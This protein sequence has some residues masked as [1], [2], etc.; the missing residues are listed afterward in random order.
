MEP[1]PYES[2]HCAQEPIPEAPPIESL[3]V[4][5]LF[6]YTLTAMLLAIG[7]GMLVDV[8]R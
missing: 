1:N 7:M 3:E 5:K 8:L 2:P 6:L 4:F